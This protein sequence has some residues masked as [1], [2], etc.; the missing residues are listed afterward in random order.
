[1]QDYIPLVHRVAG[2]EDG[3]LASSSGAVV[4]KPCQPAELAFY[5]NL[6]PKLSET[7]VGT[8]TPKF[9]GTLQLQG[10]MNQNGELEQ[11]SAEKMLDKQVGFVF[12][13]GNGRN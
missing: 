3:V 6:G 11:I 12:F 7:F 13:Q 2:H 9:Y 10:K 4:V 5:T 8:W 1:M